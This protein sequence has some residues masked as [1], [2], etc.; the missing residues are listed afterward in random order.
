MSKIYIII[1][2]YKVEKYLERCVKSAVN[3]RGV[4]KEI[5][6]VDD[7]SPDACPMLCDRLAAEHECI[8][9]IHKENGGLSDARN[10]G[11]KPVC[12]EADG[13]DY[14][15]FLDSD[16]YLHVDFSAEMISLCEKYK[17]DSAQCD[18]EKGDR[19]ELTPFA[20]EKKDFCLTGEEALLFQGL[21]SQSCA[22]IYK[23]KCFSEVLFPLG[24]INE[25]EF[26]TWKAIY[27][28]QRVAFTNLSLYYYFQHGSGI[29]SDVAKK[30]KGNPRRY[31]FLKA[32]EER[33]EFF[34]K[35]NKPVQVMRTREKICTDII[36]RYCE[37]MYLKRKDRDEDC[38]NG[39]YTE[40]YK[41]NYSLMI[42]RPG[43][44]PK[45]K[46]MYICFRYFPLSAVI[47]GKIFTLRK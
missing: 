22:K 46:L 44:A 32:Y 21:K 9:V 45:R 30:L 24:V 12:K 34:K 10:A 8:R 40:I 13:E 36:L 18:Y 2:V 19:D 26:T 38:I 7:G 42:K 15:T 29:M 16:D 25:D 47:M 17:A 33:A 28:S 35:E 3:Q 5:I 31:D 20:A 1:P 43:I 6:L 23:V 41:E 39:K 14:I 27:R 37:Q 4:E 11:L